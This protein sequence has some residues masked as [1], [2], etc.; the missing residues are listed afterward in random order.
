MCIK[1]ISESTEERKK[2]VKENFERIRPLLDDGYIYSKA[3]REVFDIP[4]GRL[5]RNKASYREL[6]EYG[7]SIGYLYVD[8]SGKGGGKK[9]CQK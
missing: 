6:I 1:V 7:E 2:K 4:I 8:Y 3:I 9:R 5:N